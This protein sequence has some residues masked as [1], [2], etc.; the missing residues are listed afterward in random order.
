MSTIFACY[1][2]DQAVNATMAEAMLSA[3][4]YWQPDA[5]DCK[6]SQGQDC[7][8]AKALLYNTARSKEDCVH[9]SA[10]RA[11]SITANARIDNRDELFESLGLDAAAH[12]PMSDGELILKAYQQWGES[13]PEHLLGDFVFIL[14]DEH[15]QQ[16]FCA[17]DHFGIKGLYYSQHDDGVMVSNEHNAFFTS[18]WQKKAIKE[19]WLVT[20]LWG[21]GGND[22]ASPCHGIEVL[23]PA[24]SLTAKN[25][26]VT[27]RPYW[28]LEENQQWH[29]AEDE[30]LMTELKQRFL[31]AVQ[32]RLDSDY[33]LGCELSE[34]LD[35]NG[36]AGHAAQQLGTA[37]LHT[38]S[39]QCQQLNDD[40]RVV[41][42]KTYADIEAM[43]AMHDNLKP[44][45]TS[46]SPPE[47]QEEL[48][49]LQSHLG[50][51]T[52]SHYGPVFYSQLAQKRHIR[53]M[54]SGWGGDHCVSAPGY[55][56]ADE[57][58]R[59][60]S[61]RQLWRLL[62]S[63][64]VVRHGSHPLKCWLRLTLC[65]ATPSLYRMITS[66]RKSLERA[67]WQRAKVNP[68]RAQWVNRYQC[69]EALQYFNDHYQ[70]DSISG[71]HQRELFEIGVEGRLMKTEQAARCNRIEYR[72]PML[73]VPLVELAYNLPSHL[74]MHKGMERY[75]FRRVLE[76]VTTQRIQWRGKADVAFPN[77]DRFAQGEEKRARL[78]KAIEGSATLSRYLDTGKLKVKSEETDFYALQNVELLEMLAETLE[79][80]DV[81]ADES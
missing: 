10:D 38:F 2:Y 51:V 44:V 7:L 71:Y 79:K 63:R 77:I 15:K 41:W 20:Q 78:I 16:L 80:V 67:L 53:V 18:A 8:L 72:F 3:S 42:E 62:S 58:F 9:Q 33:P 19:R 30:A 13:C 23:P 48:R 35:S 59:K 4:T 26:G 14:W 32:R 1:Q 75:A 5:T 46:E 65:H 27:V 31:T 47:P 70:R 74:K 22:G 56:Y 69:R 57:L 43:L 55:Q 50:A 45:W 17:R 66:Y 68:L 64:Q 24:H 11:L 76:G 49:Q 73:D 36:I 61:W 37:P 54:L 60:G 12:A 29:N 6:H 39:F 25:S 52:G 21:V 40:N 81:V 28:S 34:G